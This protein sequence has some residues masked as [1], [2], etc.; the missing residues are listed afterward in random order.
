VAPR[1][2]PQRLR[3]H[4]RDRDLP[5][6]SQHGSRNRSDGPRPPTGSSG[7]SDAAESPSMQSPAKMRRATGSGGGSPRPRREAFAMLYVGIDCAYRRA[8]WCARSRGG[9]I[10]AEGLTPADDDGLAKLVPALGQEFTACVEMMS[11]AVRVRDCLRSAGWQ[12]QIAD[13]RKSRRLRRWCARPTKSMLG[14]SRSCVAVIWC[15]RCGCR[16]SLARG[17]ARAAQPPRA[18]DSHADHREEPGARRIEPRGSAHPGPD[19]GHR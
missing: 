5:R 18:C 16:R 8:A 14:C 2:P 17:T 6:R 12:V 9:E 4:R 10:Q 7:R 11:G 13:A 19:T 15:R 1:D 3:S